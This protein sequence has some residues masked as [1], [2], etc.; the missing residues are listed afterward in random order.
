MRLLMVSTL[1]I[2]A[3]SSPSWA[4]EPKKLWEAGGFKNPESAIYDPAAAAIYV[5]N[6]NGKPTQKDGNGF[7]SKLAPDGTVVTLEWVKGLDS[8]TGLALAG[9]TLYAA[10]VDRIVAIDVAKGEV[11]AR[12]EAPGAK[13]LNDLTADRQG[14]VYASDMPANA[15]WVLD[16]GKLSVLLQDDALDNPNGLLAEN[17]QLV[18]GSWGKMA[19]DGSTKVPGH[20]K[21]VD[22]ATR[23]VADLGDPAPAGNLDG[24]VPDGK[25]GY[26][27]TDWVGGVLL[28][29]AADGKAKRLL[30]L[31]QGSADLGIVPGE[32]IV[33]IPMM[34]EGQVVAYRVD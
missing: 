22:L 32:G 23:K 10:D 33:L 13:F 11:T 34:M 20:M 24:I 4:A 30:P 12:H 21:V 6:V 18:V 9:G 27:V 29:V 26:L 8:P 25:G 14:R 3:V 19:E 7:I 16:G 28:Q 5:S 2:V 15:I 31:K 1:V 17:G